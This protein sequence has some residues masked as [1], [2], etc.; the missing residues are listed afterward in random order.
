MARRVYSRRASWFGGRRKGV[1]KAE[2]YFAEARECV[3][4]GLEKGKGVEEEREGLEE[5]G[6]LAG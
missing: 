5:T 4:L 6:V 1:G 2:G 3:R